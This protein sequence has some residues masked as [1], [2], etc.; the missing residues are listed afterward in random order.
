MALYCHTNKGHYYI[1]AFVQRSDGQII[2]ISLN[3]V[4]SGEN[5]FNS[6]LVRTA[7]SDKDYRGGH[8]SYSNVEDLSFLISKII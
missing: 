1:S 8:N 3:D 4:R 7:A 5:T 6:I 2:Y